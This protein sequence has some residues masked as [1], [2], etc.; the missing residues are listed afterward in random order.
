MV[1]CH[2]GYCVAHTGD[3]STSFGTSLGVI[4][5]ALESSGMPLGSILVALG[6]SGTLP[7]GLWCHLVSFGLAMGAEKV[8]K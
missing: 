4:L 6:S 8:L 5:E 3:L 2:F 7:G 1:L